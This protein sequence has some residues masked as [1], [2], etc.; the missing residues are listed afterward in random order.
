MSHTAPASDLVA[1]IYLDALARLI[2]DAPPDEARLWLLAMLGHAYSA[3][4]LMGGNQKSKFR[5]LLLGQEEDERLFDFLCEADDRA[6]VRLVLAALHGAGESVHSMAGDT[7]N[8]ARTAAVR[9]NPEAVMYP[10][11]WLRRLW[12]ERPYARSFKEMAGHYRDHLSRVGRGDVAEPGALFAD[13]LEKPQATILGWHMQHNGQGEPMFDRAIHGINDML[14]VRQPGRWDVIQKSLNAAFSLSGRDFSGLVV[15][16]LE[17]PPSLAGKGLVRADGSLTLR[18]LGDLIGRGVQVRVSDPSAYVSSVAAVSETISQGLGRN[19]LAH[20]LG[21][22]LKTSLLGIG[23]AVAR[24]KVNQEVERMTPRPEDQLFPPG[25]SDPYIDGPQAAP[26]A[27]GATGYR[28]APPPPSWNAGV[29]NYG[30][31]APMGTPDPRDFEGIPMQ[32]LPMQMYVPPA[33]SIPPAL[34]AASLAVPLSVGGPTAR[35]ERDAWGNAPAV[36][37]PATPNS[38]EGGGSGTPSV[39][40][41]VPDAAGSGNPIPP[42]MGDFPLPRASRGIV[43]QRGARGPK[44]RLTKL[45]PLP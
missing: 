22:I 20:S 40:D 4:R 44:F 34:S 17:I 11:N 19:A 28:Y 45:Q 12:Q 41:A 29:P 25:F 38:G 35:Y 43:A 3:D 37:N 16:G 9:I 23:F 39:D 15:R 42:N 33:R 24:S 14:K 7:P 27:P 26:A 36:I 6:A 13:T 18:Q 8:A 1:E 21:N 10:A 30:P 32:G 31:S 2:R 5:P